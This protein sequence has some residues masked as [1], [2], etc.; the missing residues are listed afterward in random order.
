MCCLLLCTS[1]SVFLSFFPSI[2]VN[3]FATVYAP[4]FPFPPLFLLVLTTRDNCLCIF[5]F[6]QC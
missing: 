1:V 2:F 4:W 6:F 5:F 3:V